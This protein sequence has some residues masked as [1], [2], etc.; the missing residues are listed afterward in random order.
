MRMQFNSIFNSIQMNFSSTAT[1]YAGQEMGSSGRTSL[2]GS[3]LASY[4]PRR[5]IL[6][7]ARVQTKPNLNI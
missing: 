3:L 1:R 7:A 5:Q 2:G 4:A 6:R